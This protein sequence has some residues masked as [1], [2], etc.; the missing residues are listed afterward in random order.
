MAVAAFQGVKLPTS[1]AP[2]YVR[3]SLYKYQGTG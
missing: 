2:E 1:T 3:A